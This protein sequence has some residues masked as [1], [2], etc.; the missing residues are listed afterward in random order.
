M[1]RAAGVLDVRYG[2]EMAVLRTPSQ[3]G[4]LAVLFM[5]LAVFPLVAER[6]SV[7]AVIQM[8]IW[9]VA[10]HGLNLLT[11][12]AGQISIGHAAFVGVGCYTVGVLTARL[13]MNYFLAL[14]LA[15]LAAGIIGL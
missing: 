14:P 4:A 7:I 6:S 3:W 12:Y 11:G 13:G 2:T 1:T 8:A 9:L 10:A 15:G 5:G